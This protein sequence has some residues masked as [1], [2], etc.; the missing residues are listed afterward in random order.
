MKI[1]FASD[2]H[3]SALRTE[4]ALDAADRHGAEWIVLLGDILNHG[5]RNR[6]PEGYDTLATARMLNERADRIMA[7]RGNCDGEVDGMVLK[8][9]VSAD[10]SWLTVGTRRVFLT[11]GHMWSPDNLPLLRPGDAFA[12]GHTH[13]WKAEVQDGIHIWN[14]GSV[15][16]PKQGLP[17][18]FGLLDNNVFHVLDIEGREIASDEPGIGAPLHIAAKTA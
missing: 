18:T 16:L 4:I 17:P 8:F 15:S 10:Y 7:V 5:P 12:Y 2:L 9:P 14:P 13:V 3:G 11:H 6:L 1:L